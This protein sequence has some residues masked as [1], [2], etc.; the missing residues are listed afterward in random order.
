[1]AITKIVPIDIDDMTYDHEIVD[2][3]SNTDSEILN[4][5][6]VEPTPEIVDN[7]IMEKTYIQQ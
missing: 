1:M 3:S 7:F 6:I 5:E 2:A 4:D